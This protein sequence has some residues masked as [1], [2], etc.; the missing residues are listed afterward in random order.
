MAE[1][2]CERREISVCQADKGGA[3][4]MV[5][6]KYSEERVR[7]KLYDERLYVQ[8]KNDPRPTLYQEVIDLWSV[9]KSEGFVSE[10]EAKEIVGITERGNKSTASRFKPGTT[11][12]VPSLK[13][14]KLAP[15]DIVPGCE[16]PVRL[17]SCLQEGVTKRSD[18][19]IAHK[20][21]K[22]LA[23]D[24]SK[25]MLKDTNDA[26]KW[27]EEMEKK[28]KKAKKSFTPFTF[29]F[30]SL[31]DRLDPDLVVK[32]LEDAMESCRAHWSKGFM[33]WMI[34]VIRLSMESAFGEFKGRFFRAVG[35]IPTGGS[36]SVELANIAV[37]FILK[38]E[39]FE[40]DK[41]MKDI[42][43]IKRFI[44]DG[45][46]IH[47][48]SERRFSA[49]KKL[50]SKKVAKHGMKIKPGDW[51]VPLDKYHPVNFLDI[52][53]SFDEN[54]SLQTDLFTKPTDAR[55][56]LNFSSCHPNYTFSGNVYSQALRLR[57]I[58]NCDVRLASRLDE[59][60]LDFKKS[61]YPD[62]MLTNIINKVKVCKRTL[63][64]PDNQGDTEKDEDTIMVI[65]TFGRD[66]ILTDATKKIEKNS[67]S[68]KF[69]Y[70][71][72]TGPSI[73]SMV[74][75][76]KASALGQPYGKTE[77]CNNNAN[78]KGCNMMS[79]QDFVVDYYEK[80]F[81][82]AR[83]KC[84]SNNLIYYAKCKHCSKGYVGKTTQK[85]NGRISGH[86]GKF[87]VFLHHDT[88][89]LNDEDNLLGLHLFHKHHLN[90]KTAFDDSYTFTI[91]EKCN[92]KYL[93]LKE[94]VWGQK[95][96]CVAPYGL[97]SHDPFGI[98][99]VL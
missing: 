98:P 22:S 25:D 42:V 59:L 64:K 55:S 30:D 27:L 43:G 83:G 16:I 3:I 32:A 50:V 96:K 51:S 17:I 8:I 63:D 21:L 86:R 2:E 34:K 61:G 87:N 76:S 81:R 39:I 47:T 60:K 71:K 75:K 41:L 79:N 19:F 6:A 56:Y 46:G 95:L 13:I 5:P 99:V 12:F 68:I 31:Y 4:L 20:W 52:Q 92:P 23:R 67:E 89:Q 91:L 69:R 18:V 36:I 40:D 74:V 10:F 97:N 15:E 28:S 49:W 73:K 38:T 78:C 1:K 44:D 9:G 48:M 54:K 57:R 35:G 37:Y 24:Y 29:D 88:S 14:H 93:D 84:N 26:L 65:S 58:I 53:F 94:H 33:E 82:S 72:K 77:R 90:N 45:V 7:R 70:V 80:K 62:K 66:K 11:Y 85:L